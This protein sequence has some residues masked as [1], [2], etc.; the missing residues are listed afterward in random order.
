[1]W[2]YH[3][4]PNSWNFNEVGLLKEHDM[5]ENEELILK[6]AQYYVDSAQEFLSYDE[7]MDLKI[8]VENA[9]RQFGIGKND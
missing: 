7:M 9:L 6:I 2:R 3:Y 4:G 5:K 8:K 1:M